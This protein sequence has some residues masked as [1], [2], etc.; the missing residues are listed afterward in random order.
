M[1]HP[2]TRMWNV[3]YLEIHRILTSHLIFLSDPS[4]ILFKV[5][6]SDV[7]EIEMLSPPPLGISNAHIL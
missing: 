2:E 4:K 5:P 7:V 3:L 6:A 1:C